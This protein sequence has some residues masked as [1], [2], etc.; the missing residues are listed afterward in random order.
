MI[1]RITSLLF[2]VCISLAAQNQSAY[3]SND[4][5]KNG[6][7]F[8]PSRLS[9]Q[10]SLSFGAM[11]NGST[12]NGLQSQS[13]YSTMMRYQF[14]AP[15]TLNL[16]FGLPIHSSFSPMQN[17]SSG[18]LQSFEYFKSMPFNMS[19]DWQPRENMHFI[20]SRKKRCRGEAPDLYY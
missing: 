10:N 14:T 18:N 9:I 17:L 20:F 13:L 8:D 11:T 19:L 1:I 15:V 16:N 3:E 7:L 6:G 4:D 5:Q 12:S 2:I